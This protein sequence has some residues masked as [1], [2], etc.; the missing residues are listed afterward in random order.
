MASPT[1]WGPTS[2]VLPTSNIFLN[3]LLS[4]AKW[5]GP[6]GQG[7]TVTYSFP[8]GGSSFWST[9][10][11]TGYGPQ[12]G[13]GEPWNSS[14]RGL[15]L[16]EQA[17]IETA[18]RAWSKVA[19][20]S[21][22]EV[23]DNASVAGDMRFAFTSDSTA[24]AYFPAA[25]AIAG[26]TWFGRGMDGLGI[27]G[28]YGFAT[29]L[30]EI[31]H[32]IGL[33][34]P[35][36]VVGDYNA[37]PMDWDSIEFSIMSYRSHV[38][39]SS[40]GSYTNET[41]GHA[42]GPMIYDILTLQY[43]YGANFGTNK[44]NTVYAWSAATG[45]A[46][47][48]GVGQGAP[49]GNRVFET[50][51]DGGGTDTY[52]FSNYST[53]LSVNL[54]PGGW[55]AIS[56]GQRSNLGDGFFARG[57]VFNAFQYNGDPRSLIENAKG[58]SGNDLISGNIGRNSLFGNAGDDVLNG[59]TGSDIL[60]GGADE[61]AFVF[62]TALSASQNVDTI[63][64]FVHADDAIWIENAIFKKVGGAGV[65]KAGAFANWSAKDQADDRII[66]RHLD[67][68]DRGS[69]KDVIELYYDPTGGKTSDAVLFARLTGQPKVTL[70]AGDILIV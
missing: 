33:K 27:R 39:A 19:N 52:D 1:T 18:L 49:G 20:I 66:Y 41:W 65:L 50:I 11:G 60:S 45:E 70:N 68:S 44:G 51:W 15:T 26:D 7:V 35:H 58:G 38:G 5:G 48:N 4:G 61:D 34:H 69:A 37:L 63:R 13:A 10:T 54:W 6:A 16:N 55:S 2:S 56:D 28:S 67:S 64:G 62:S 32:A 57:N 31:G 21:F 23:V 29:V 59:Q 12:I 53:N 46:F 43:M 30:H 9:D 22:R 3:G 8:Q 17:I 36:D 25:S 40:S 42:Q 14:F 47:I 24:H